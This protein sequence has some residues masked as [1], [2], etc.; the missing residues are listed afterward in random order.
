MTAVVQF[1]MFNE[2]KRVI[3]KELNDDYV[4]VARGEEGGC[5]T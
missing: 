1:G 5:L 3:K 2:K 4:K